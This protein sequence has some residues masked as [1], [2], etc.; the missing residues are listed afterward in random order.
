MQ[1]LAEVRTCSWRSLP[2]RAPQYIATLRRCKM[3]ERLRSA[4]RAMHARFPFSEALWL[5]WLDDELP[6]AREPDARAQAEALLDTAVQD[7]L[8]VPVW[9]RYLRCA[10]S[11]PPRAPPPCVRAACGAPAA[12]LC[13]AAGRTRRRRARCPVACPLYLLRPRGPRSPG[14]QGS[15]GLGARAATRAPEGRVP[16]QVPAGQ[17]PGRARAHRRG[18]GQVPRCGGARAHGRRPAPAG[19]RAAVDRIQ[20]LALDPAPG[21]PCRSPIAYALSLARRPPIHSM[22]EIEPARGGVRPSKAAVGGR[23]RR[24]ATA[25]MSLTCPAVCHTADACGLRPRLCRVPSPATA[26]S[27][28]GAHMR[29]C[30]RDYEAA[31]AAAQGHADREQVQRVRDLFHRQLKVRRPPAPAAPPPALRAPSGARWKACWGCSAVR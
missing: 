3:R 5:E 18:P 22:C 26:V 31:A 1:S 28:D 13:R 7:Y 6:G 9:A 24:S 29:M 4:R 12:A 25:Y 30:C 2:C 8:S 15:P 11:P 23:R 17:R 21:R 27:S 14:R 19:R 10:R 20:A 16:A